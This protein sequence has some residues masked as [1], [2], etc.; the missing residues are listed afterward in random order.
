MPYHKRNL[1]VRR[2]TDTPLGVGAPHAKN[3][4]SDD[5]VFSR[6]VVCDAWPR[7]DDVL[8]YLKRRGKIGPSNTYYSHGV[9]LYY[10][11][12]FVIKIFYFVAHKAENIQ[13]TKLLLHK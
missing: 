9:L 8:N 5:T 6:C 13:V 3:R 10:F 12:F 1:Y 2:W 4:V 11:A 7:N